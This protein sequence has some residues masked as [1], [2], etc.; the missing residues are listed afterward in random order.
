MKSKK[1]KNLIEQGIKEQDAYYQKKNQ[2]ERLK[3]QKQDDP[4]KP[5]LLKRFACILLD[6]LMILVVLL[7]L[8][9]ASFFL[10]LDKLGY[11]DDQNYIQESI[12]N[13]HLYKQNEIGNYVAITSL[14]DS[15][16]SP[17]ENFDEAI[18]Y[19]YSTD[20]RALEDRKLEEY[21]SS[22]INSGLF[23]LEGGDYVRS[24][25]ANDDKVKSF[26]VKEYKL[27][28][29]YLQ[30]DPEYVY[31]SNHS[32]LLAILSMM[33]C[34]VISSGIFYLLVPLLTKGHCTIGQ[35]ACK[36]ILVNMED[37]KEATNKQVVYRYLVLLLTTYILPLSIMLMSTDFAGLPIFINAGVICFTKNNESFHGFFSQTKIIN[38]SG[39]NMMES[40]KQIKEMID[41]EK[42]NN[43]E[44]FN[45][46]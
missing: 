8:Q 24:T 10:V 31:C 12:I 46:E 9:L 15:S 33:A 45:K 29:K 5:N 18:I 37:K 2:E 20:L 23:I 13:S 1:E 17:E 4:A 32:L 6:G 27:A 14:Y 44:L 35:M 7:G 34:S 40:Y 22:K 28:L 43:P 26:L 11:R 41:V 16:I 38:K 3:K 25:D 30:S 21:Y 39:T 36:L 42:Q 19:F